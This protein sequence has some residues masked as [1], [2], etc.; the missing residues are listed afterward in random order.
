[1]RPVIAMFKEILY[2]L[3]IKNIVVEK[4]VNREC[5]R[6]LEI[7]KTLPH[8]AV[9]SGIIQIIG[10]DRRYAPFRLKGKSFFQGPVDFFRINRKYEIL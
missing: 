9:I 5:S 8:F 6:F 10:M 1:M 2:V 7:A 4:G 3:Y